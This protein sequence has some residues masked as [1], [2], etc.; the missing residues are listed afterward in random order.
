MKVIVFLKVFKV[1]SSFRKCKKKIQK[2]FFVS[3]MNASEKV[4]VNCLY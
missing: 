3:E 2:I 1:E 4:A